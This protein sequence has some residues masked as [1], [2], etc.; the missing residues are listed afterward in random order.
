MKLQGNLR[1]AM[2]LVFLCIFGSCKHPPVDIFLTL[3]LK[4]VRSDSSSDYQLDQIPTFV[5]M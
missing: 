2:W 4:D 5:G 1:L 3:K